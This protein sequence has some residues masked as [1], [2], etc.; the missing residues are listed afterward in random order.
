MQVASSS[1]STDKETWGKML[2]FAYLPPILADKFICSVP[3]TSSPDIKTSFF[4]FPTHAKDQQ[5]YR[6]PPGLLWQ[7]GTDETSA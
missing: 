2:L 1:S 5:L 4:G 3:S 6:N 7:A